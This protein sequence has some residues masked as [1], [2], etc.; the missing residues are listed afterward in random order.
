M[1]ILPS[2]RTDYDMFNVKRKVGEQ[3][4][5]RMAAFPADMTKDLKASPALWRCRPVHG[6]N[7]LR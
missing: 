5:T 2:G 4:A 7:A 6:S 1:L 3:Q